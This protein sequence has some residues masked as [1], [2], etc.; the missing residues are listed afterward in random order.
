MVEL[1]TQEKAQHWSFVH[2]KHLTQ[3]DKSCIWPSVNIHLILSIHVKYTCKYVNNTLQSLLQGYT[4]KRNFHEPYRH[5]EGAAMGELVCWSIGSSHLCLP[6]QFEE[7]MVDIC[8]R[9]LDVNPKHARDP[10]NDVSAR[11][12]PIYVS[13]VVSAMVGPEFF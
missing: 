5:T 3:N 6:I 8:L 12:N 4:G 13:R 9:L 11:C 10:A 2:Q 1:S 7:E